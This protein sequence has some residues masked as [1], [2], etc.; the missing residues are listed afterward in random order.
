MGLLGPLHGGRA[1]PDHGV[2]LGQFGQR[3]PRVGH[4]LGGVDGDGGV[5]GQRT[6]QGHLVRGEGARRAVGGEQGAD[7]LAAAAGTQQQ[8][9][10]ED[11]DQAL[12]QDTGVDARR[13]VEAFVRAVVGRGVGARGLRDQAAEPLAELQPQVLEQLGHRAVGDA[14]EG[15]ARLLVGQRQVRRVGAEQH[16]GAADDG[17]Q[18]RVQVAQRGE[19]AGGVEEGGEFRLPALVL[20]QCAVHAQGGLGGL[21]DLREAVAADPGPPRLGGDGAEVLGG[22][23]GG[24]EV[25]EPAQVGGDGRVR[26]HGRTIVRKRG[27]PRKR[28][29]VRRTRSPSD[30]RPGG[31]RRRLRCRRGSPPDRPVRPRPGRCRGSRGRGPRRSR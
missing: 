20:P 14:H 26:G 3:D 7:H 27:G 30:R 2:G 29:G 19:I 24:E 6:Q 13:V 25:E 15:V 22:G 10:A 18:H 1:L 5:V 21:L 31:P 17:P 16:P 23:A 28:A 4:G 9:N 8:G 12:V 11:R